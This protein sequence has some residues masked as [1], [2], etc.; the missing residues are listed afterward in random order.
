[1]SINGL[2]LANGTPIIRSTRKSAIRRIAITIPVKH[3]AFGIRSILWNALVDLNTA[4][5]M[6]A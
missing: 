2:A 6:T 3:R 1:M 4:D 5:A